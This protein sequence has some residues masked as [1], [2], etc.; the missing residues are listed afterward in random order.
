M[1]N[2]KFVISSVLV[3]SMVLGMTSCSMFDDAGKQ[4]TEVGDE[5]ME[6]LI[7]R[8]VEDMAELC[9]DEDEALEI[10]IPY[11]GDM[12]A[13]KAI[14]SNATFEAGKPE[15]KTKD[16]K[17]EIEYTLTLPDYESCLDEDPED[18]DELEDLLEDTEDTIEIKVTLEFKLKKDEWL[19]DNVEDIAEDVFGE[20]YDVDWGF[21]SPLASKIDYIYFDSWNDDDVYYT[22]TNHMKFNVY[23]TEEVEE[24]LTFEVV[25]DGV[26]VFQADVNYIGIYDQA[27]CYVEP[28]D[29]GVSEFEAG[30][31]T[32]NVYDSHRGLIISATCTV[33]A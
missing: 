4:C 18:M 5:F 6:A 29:L 30:D 23:F 31:Y 26:V 11:C 16:K 7:D 3:T 21:E 1:K 14:L 10:F 13:V 33:V 32:F 20:L 27:D 25:K 17:G 22:D 8:N 28:E 2:S 9:T 24:D 12:E 15:C 19:I